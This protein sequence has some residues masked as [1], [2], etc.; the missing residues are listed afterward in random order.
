MPKAPLDLAIAHGKAQAPSVLR[1][2]QTADHGVLAVELDQV[3]FG[4]ILNLNLS[5]HISRVTLYLSYATYATFAMHK[6]SVTDLKNCIGD[7]QRR[8]DAN[9]DEAIALTWYGKVRA[10]VLSR[11]QFEDMG[12]DVEKIQ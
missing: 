9:P 4:E 3:I 11:Q 6:I 5:W 7:M 8:L 10:V 2:A 12:G 1:C